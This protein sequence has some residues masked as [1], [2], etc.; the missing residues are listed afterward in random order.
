MVKQNDQDVFQ[1][2]LPVAYFILALR[3]MNVWK[4]FIKVAV[5]NKLFQMDKVK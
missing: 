3:E 2:V 5:K 1:S 4:E